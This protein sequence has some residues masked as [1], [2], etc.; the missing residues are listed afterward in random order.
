MKQASNS[1][2]GGLVLDMHP[3]TTQNTQLTDALNATLITFNGNEMMLQNDMG[4]TLI[5]DSATGNIMGLSPGFIPIGMKEHGGIMYIASVNKEGEGEIGTIPSPIIRDFYKDRVIFEV[6]QSIPIN[7]GDALKI[8]NKLYPADKFIA[9]LQMEIN[10]TDLIGQKFKKNSGLSPSPESDPSDIILGRDVIRYTAG[11]AEKQT[12]YTPVLSY[13]SNISKILLQGDQKETDLFSSKGIYSLELYSRHDNSSDIPANSLSSLQIYQHDGDFKESNYWY[14][15]TASPTDVFPKDLLIATLNKDLKQFPSNNKPGYLAVK[16]QTEGINKFDILPRAKDPFYT[17]ITYKSYQSES[18]SQYYT[19][20][21]GFYYSTD[22]GIYIDRI[23]ARV[24]DEST[25]KEM[26]LVYP[27]STTIPQF[28]INNL[29]ND[30]LFNSFLD[31]PELDDLFKNNG[32]TDHIY[33][34]YSNTLPQVQSVSDNKSFILTTLKQIEDH[35]QT[36]MESSTEGGNKT[37]GGVFCVPL[38]EKYNNWYRAEIDYYDQY[39]NKQGTFTKRFNPYL[40]DVFGTN[41][42]VEQ[43]ESVKGIVMGNKDVELQWEYKYDLPSIT[44]SYAIHRFPEKNGW[45]TTYANTKGKV[46][47]RRDGEDKADYNQTFYLSEQVLPSI[48][49][50]PDVPADDYEYLYADNRSNVTYEWNI[51]TPTIKV[52]SQIL[53]MKGLYGM[54]DSNGYKGKYCN[55]LQFG[56]FNNVT[57]EQ[58]YDRIQLAGAELNSADIVGTVA[59][60]GFK[61]FQYNTIKTEFSEPFWISSAHYDTSIFTTRELADP[62]VMH[63]VDNTTGSSEQT[64]FGDPV[65]IPLNIKIQD[66]VASGFGL[67][68]QLDNDNPY[69]P[70]NPIAFPNLFWVIQSKANTQW[71]DAHFE[72][73]SNICVQWEDQQK[74]TLTLSKK[75]NPSYSITPYFCLTGTNNEGKQVYVQRF[76]KK[77]STDIVYEHNFELDTNGKPVNYYVETSNSFESVIHSC[78]YTHEHPFYYYQQKLSYTNTLQ[79]GIYVLN[80]Q[81]VPGAAKA[82][83][84]TVFHQDAVLTITIG[85]ISKSFN[86]DTGWVIQPSYNEGITNRGISDKD[87]RGVYSP[88]VIFVPNKQQIKITTDKDFFRQNIGLYKIKTCSGSEI[89]DLVAL[90]QDMISSYCTYMYNL[91]QTA[92]HL[93]SQD[94]VKEYSFIQKYGVFFKESYVFIDGL[95]NQGDIV[96]INVENQYYQ[97]Y[98][99]IP[100][101]PSILPISISPFYPKG[102]ET[103][104]NAY[105]MPESVLNVSDDDYPNFVFSNPIKDWSFSTKPLS[106][107]LRQLV[108]Q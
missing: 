107:N 80:I 48:T 94:K 84:N 5:Q 30:S 56:G 95:V 51:P 27:Y 78:T 81:R 43:V 66:S 71:Y 89:Q 47:M 52:T 15:H 33:N 42:S 34:A 31:N 6:N 35:D 103:T 32:N 64:N 38:G 99:F 58:G 73:K 21:P 50:T 23:E 12:L 65:S 75:S 101:D 44:N 93:Y 105:V 9:N 100:S 45:A 29:E 72:V 40:N 37:Y 92:E 25:A 98:P 17:P 102:S 57:S 39:N 60:V 4:N 68:F 18:G 104:W 19:Y 2:T 97:S 70:A 108:E 28:T 54:D 24:I 26:K 20:F 87:D 1:F 59:S 85:N 106:G 69:S 74:W 8:S 63:T 86:A 67:L 36:D 13:N 49:A 46:Q 83:Q 22:S 14:L 10:E 90:Q 55:Y 91:S 41:L 96:G 7:V 61:E 76:G 53:S 62:I 88:I 79:P 3:L 11:Q 77:D 82:Q 16:L